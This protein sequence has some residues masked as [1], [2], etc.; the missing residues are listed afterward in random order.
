MLIASLEQAKDL[1]SELKA[2]KEFYRKVQNIVMIS[3]MKN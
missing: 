2:K 1:I 3:M